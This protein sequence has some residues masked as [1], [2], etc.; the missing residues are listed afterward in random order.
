MQGQGWPNTLSQIM[1]T[2]AQTLPSQTSM[3][4]N[5]G[6]ISPGCGLVNLLT[7]VGQRS[8]PYPTWAGDQRCL[9]LLYGQLQ[10]S[11]CSSFST[12]G[13]M[14]VGVHIPCIA[15]LQENGPV[16]LGTWLRQRGSPPFPGVYS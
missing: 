10:L 14:W 2:G 13:S 5:P 6:F 7:D 12:C 4:G 9:A 8:V 3:R 1:G 15:S 11:S 16:K